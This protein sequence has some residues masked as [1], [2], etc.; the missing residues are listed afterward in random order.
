MDSLGL[1]LKRLRYL[2]PLFLFAAVLLFY[3]IWKITENEFNQ[4]PLIKTNEAVNSIVFFAK[5]YKGSTL[6]VDTQGRYFSIMAY[7]WDIKPTVLYYHLEKGDS[8]SRKPY[9]DILYLYKKKDGSFIE[10]EVKSL[11]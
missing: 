11:E 3:L 7:N 4:F 5:E 8:I 6:L 10:F 9:S 2:V 1:N